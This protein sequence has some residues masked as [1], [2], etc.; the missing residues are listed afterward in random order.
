MR[1]CARSARSA[2]RKLRA[3]ICRRS[4]AVGTQ[5]TSLE[6]ELRAVEQRLKSEVA[7]RAG[8]KGQ[9]AEAAAAQARSDDALSKLQAECDEKE[10]AIAA[11]LKKAAD[12]S[13]ELASTSSKLEEAVAERE[14][15]VAELAS[16]QVTLASLREGLSAKEAEVCSIEEGASELSCMLEGQ[17]EAAVEMCGALI[18]QQQAAEETMGTAW[19]ALE[20]ELAAEEASIDAAFNA[21]PE[22]ASLAK[23]NEKLETLT[24]QAKSDTAGRARAQLACRLAQL[25]SG[26]SSIDE[27]GVVFATIDAD[28]SGEIDLD[29][30]KQAIGR[31]GFACGIDQT[32]C[33]DDDEIERLFNDI[34]TD[35]SGEISYAEFLSAAQRDSPLPDWLLSNAWVQEQV[36]NARIN[37]LDEALASAETKLSSTLSALNATQVQLPPA[38]QADAAVRESY[39]A[40]KA[41]FAANATA[42]IAALEQQVGNRATLVEAREQLTLS[43]ALNETIRKPLA[44]LALQESPAGGS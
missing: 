34:D 26:A 18:V 36:D 1:W 25:E 9:V 33:I 15:V 39:E 8:A 29:E 31:S 41:A 3:P 28:G 24:A 14:K 12:L 5:V 16:V 13:A 17:L 27:L 43:R 6:G 2:R 40:D 42:Q 11:A 10:T 30:F 32:D 44:T 21:A 23:F 20:A 22:V 38:Q 7:A 4:S 19:V 35:Q 37:Q